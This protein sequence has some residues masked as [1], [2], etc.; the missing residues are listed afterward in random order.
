MRA[1]AI[2]ITVSV[3]I[4]ILAIGL[5]DCQCKSEIYAGDNLMKTVG[6]NRIYIGGTFKNTIN[7]NPRFIQTVA[8][9]KP[10][11]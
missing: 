11:V 2:D 4:S 1:H 10:K 9:R 5:S 8:L 6:V 3:D 7:V